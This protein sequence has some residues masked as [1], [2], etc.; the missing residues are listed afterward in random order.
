MMESRRIL[1]II[2]SLG[3]GGT[4]SQLT[5]LILECQ[6]KNWR[7]ELFTLDTSGPFKTVLEK[8]GIPIYDGGYDSSAGFL[9]K[10]NSL[11]KSSYYLWRVLRAT[12]PDLIHAFLPLTNFIGTTVGRLAGIKKIIISKRALSTHQDRNALWKLLDRLS[13]AFSSKITVNSKAVWQ[14]TVIRDKVNSNKLVLIYNGLNKKLFSDI[15]KNRIF[16]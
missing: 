6:R 11:I 12:K 5:L 3:L 1:Y 16:M 10:I 2:G 7:C 4:E 15:K 13:N 14:D 9:K 8:Q